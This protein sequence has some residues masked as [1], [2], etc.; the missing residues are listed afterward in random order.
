[1]APASRHRLSVDERPPSRRLTSLCELAIR[2]PPA[3]GPP[4]LVRVSTPTDFMRQF[5][6]ADKR[7]ARIHAASSIV[8]EHLKAKGYLPKGGKDG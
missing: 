8:A 5:A 4:A 1:M 3:K 2:R 7:V 6:P